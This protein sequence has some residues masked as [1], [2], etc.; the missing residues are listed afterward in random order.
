MLD[1]GPSWVI[2]IHSLVKRETGQ[3]KDIINDIYI[4]IHSLV[5]RETLDFSGNG[6]EKR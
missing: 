1:L 3:Y 6:E 5:K 2:S 4:S